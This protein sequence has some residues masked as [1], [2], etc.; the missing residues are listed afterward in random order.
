MSDTLP[1]T[2]QDA[3]VVLLDRKKRSLFGIAGAPGAGKSTLAARIA[4]QFPDDVAIV[5]MDGFHLANA[6]LDRL[7]RKG[8]KGAP[9]TF[10]V[11]GFIAL[12][13]RLKKPPTDG[14]V[15]APRFERAIE[16]PIAGATPVLASTPLIVVEGNY[17]LLDGLWSPVRSL[18]DG[19]C[20]VRTPQK[21]RLAWLL[22]RHMSFGRSREEA[23]AWIEHTDELNA[24]LIERSATRA[25]FSVEV[26]AE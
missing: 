11:A 6:E 1:A 9:D 4:A 10:D 13:H 26:G 17:L 19:C 7:G 5:P 2:L 22:D 16:E 24:V 14:I 15:Y 3:I 18:L 20:Y 25:D 12:L 8:R 23:I 21:K